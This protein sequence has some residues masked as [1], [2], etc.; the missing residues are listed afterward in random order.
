MF[1]TMLSALVT[2]TPVA[3]AI[4]GPIA[5][6]TPAAQVAPADVVRRAHLFDELNNADN[7]LGWVGRRNEAPTPDTLDELDNSN[8]GPYCWARGLNEARLSPQIFV[9]N[10]LLTS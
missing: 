2:F 3:I 8:S 4:A 7:V 10:Q 6:T 1:N 9:E 5:R